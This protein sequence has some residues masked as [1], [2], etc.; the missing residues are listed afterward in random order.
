MSMISVIGGE[1]RWQKLGYENEA[2]DVKMNEDFHFQED[3]RDV[4]IPERGKTECP[5]Y[6]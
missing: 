6:N 2:S 1:G 4:L 5:K 3:G